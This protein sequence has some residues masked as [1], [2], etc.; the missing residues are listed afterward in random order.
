M[1]GESGV[2]HVLRK[3]LVEAT[4]LRPL[5]VLAMRLQLIGDARCEAILSG[6]IP[7]F[8]THGF[9]RR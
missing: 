7:T 9:G 8:G 6:L 4:L 5:A 3:Q 1:L 2:P